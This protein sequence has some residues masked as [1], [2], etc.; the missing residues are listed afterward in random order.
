[1]TFIM[2]S[3]KHSLAKVMPF[4]YMFNAKHKIIFFSVFILAQVG[5]AVIWYMGVI[6]AKEFLTVGVWWRVE[7]G[8][9]HVARKF[10]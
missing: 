7:V 9:G 2:D 6:E 1:M 10:S 8:A 3:I 4:P 5:S